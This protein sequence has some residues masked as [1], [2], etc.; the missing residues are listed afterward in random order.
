MLPYLLWSHA[1]SKKGPKA[2]VIKKWFSPTA[3]R[4]A[5]DAFW[6]PKDECVKNQSDL[7]LAA[8][9]AADD[10]DL[11]WEADIMKPPSPKRKRPQAEEESLDDSISTVKTAMSVKKYQN[12]RSKERH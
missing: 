9:L 4:R 10:D 8:A 1:Q 12:P 2:S 5:E 6:C 11:Y 3:R 7:M